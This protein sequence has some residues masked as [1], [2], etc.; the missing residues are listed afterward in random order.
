MALTVNTN[1]ASLNAQRT[2]SRNQQAVSQVLAEL[3]SGSSINSAADNPAGLAISQGLTT[4]INGDQQALTNANSGISLTQTASGALSQITQN[5]QQ[6]QQLAIEASNGILSS[7][8]RQ[9]LQQQV[10]Q[11]TQANSQIVQ[12]TNFNGTPLLSGNNGVTL[13][14]GPNGTANNQV[15]IN[16]AGLDN[17]PANG[18]LN[19]YNAN[20]NATGTIDITT[21][22]NALHATSQITQ[23]LNTLSNTQATVGAAQ[24]SLSATINNLANTSI[25]SQAARSRISDTDFAAASAALAQN[26]ILANAGASVL[27]QAN[28]SQS[29]ALTLLR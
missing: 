3:S 16:S 22:A 19:T 2:Y 9:A 12:T 27:S 14:I 6:I 13:Q 24:N 28:V 7:S 11:L 26:Q 15:T 5:T 8:N 18:G 25:N 21:Q 17:T 1:T 23:D 4:Q 20:L 29:A 10:D